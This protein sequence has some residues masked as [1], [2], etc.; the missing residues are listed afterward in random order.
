MLKDFFELPYHVYDGDPLWVPPMIAEQKRILSHNRNPY[1]SKDVSIELFN[2][3]RSERICSRVAIIINRYYHQKY[4]TKSAF[5]GFFESVN[6][7]LAVELLFER[8]NQYLI[9][10]D[11]KRI[12]GPFNPNH[13]SELGVLAKNDDRPPSFFQTYNPAYYNDLLCSAGFEV[14]KKVHTRINSDIQHYLRELNYHHKN[15]SENGYTVRSFIN[16]RFDTELENLRDIFNDAFSE[17]WHFLPVSSSEYRFYAKY[18]NLVTYPSLIKFVEHNGNP[19]AAIQFVLDINP[20]LKKFAGRQNIFRY[21]QLLKNKKQIRKLIIFAVGIKKSYRRTPAF[22]LLLQ[23]TFDV[24]AK[25]D[26]LE[27][28]W[29]SPENESAV[30]AAKCLGLEI[31][32]EFLIYGKKINY[33]N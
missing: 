31:D 11:I 20:Y 8:V 6:D 27:T 28:T 5:F 14:L 29:M 21:L 26:V 18:L 19:V 12:E 17:N 22:H 1:F 32:K 10:H 33:S 30:H 2:C 7:P 16:H 24:A 4:G 13:Y 15:Y 9:F 25:F 3:Y 23:S